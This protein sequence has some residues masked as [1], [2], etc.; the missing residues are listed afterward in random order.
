MVDGAT[1]EDRRLRIEAKKY[2]PGS[3]HPRSSFFIGIMLSEFKGSLPFR[4]LARGER[5]E[6]IMRSF[7]IFHSKQRNPQ[8]SRRAE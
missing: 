3:R 2:A 4:E 6:E 8:E 1:G 7:G 5:K